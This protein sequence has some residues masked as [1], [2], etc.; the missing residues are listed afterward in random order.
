M[1]VMFHFF[2]DS[3]C[4]FRC[5]TEILGVIHVFSAN[6]RNHAQDPAPQTIFA[7]GASIRLSEELDLGHGF[8]VLE[9]GRYT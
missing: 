8:W 9:N 7:K 2:M 1:F 4:F 5:L 3:F 6:G